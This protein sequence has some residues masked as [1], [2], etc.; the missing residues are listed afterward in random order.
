VGFFVRVK[1]G[2]I[3]EASSNAETKQTPA[4][5]PKAPS[6]ALADLKDPI[7]KILQGEPHRGY[8][9]EDLVQILK[10]S[11]P[12]D[13]Q[14]QSQTVVKISADLRKLVEEGRITEIAPGL[15]KARLFFDKEERIEHALIGEMGNTFYRFQSPIFRL[16]I[17]V[18]SAYFIK[19]RCHGDW[20]VTV[21]DTTIGKDYCLVRRLRDGTY[22]VGARPA[23]TGEDHHLQ[24]EGRYIAKKHLT[25]TIS[26]DEISVED[27]KTPHGTRIDL[28]TQKGLARYEQVAEAFLQG[29]DSRD[30]KDPVKRGRFVLELLLNQH[31]NFETTFFS[32]VVDLLLLAG[33]EGARKA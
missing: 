9:A 22:T 25:L 23:E 10:L 28:L 17:G 11:T 32:A 15:F 8:R 2:D 24:I 13:L 30:Q 5:T 21:R 16:N 14:K 1:T 6:A 29:T 19:N 12:K 26:S 33:L 27:Q 20:V 18:L 4:P 3:M 31:Q 7:L